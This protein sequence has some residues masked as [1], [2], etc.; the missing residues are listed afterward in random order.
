[1]ITTEAAGDGCSEEPVATPASCHRRPARPTGNRLNRRDLT[2]DLCGDY[3]R[4][5][6]TAAKCS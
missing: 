6:W 3:R 4:S 5:S 1:M 2:V